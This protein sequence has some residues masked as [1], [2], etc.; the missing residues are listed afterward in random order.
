M[1]TVN[2]CKVL[3]TGDEIE[4]PKGPA[5]IHFLYDKKGKQHFD[6][7]M[8]LIDHLKVKVK[9]GTVTVYPYQIYLKGE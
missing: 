7:A 4:T 9:T 2:P 5:T 8:R 6:L 1:I 3:R